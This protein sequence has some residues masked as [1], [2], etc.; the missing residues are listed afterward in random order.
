MRPYK[1]LSHFLKLDK[2]GAEGC[3][4]KALWLLLSRRLIRSDIV[5]VSKDGFLGKGNGACF[6]KTQGNSINV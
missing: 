5:R 4:G 1:K 6:V 2:A 3:N